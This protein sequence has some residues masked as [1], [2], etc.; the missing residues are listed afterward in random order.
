[1][2][3]T[4]LVKSIQD[5]MRQDAGVDGDAQRISQLVWLLFLKIFDDKEVEYEIDPAY[6]SP[7]PE[8]LR[9]RTWATNDEGVTGDEL[10]AFINMDL[11][12]TLKGLQ[13]PP[14]ADP[15]ASSCRMSSP[16]LTTT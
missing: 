12:P 5:I 2:S 15:A 7:I 14:G 16:M 8:R 3:I 1:M 11:F 6:V 9:W 10:L 13:L 4:T